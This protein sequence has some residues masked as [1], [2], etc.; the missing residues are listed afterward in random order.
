MRGSNPWLTCDKGSIGLWAPVEDSAVFGTTGVVFTSSGALTAGRSPAG[1]VASSRSLQVAVTFGAADENEWI[2]DKSATES[3]MLALS[4]EIKPDQQLNVPV[5]GRL[6]D[7]CKRGFAVLLLLEDPWRAGVVERREMDGLRAC[8]F[9]LRALDTS[10][11]SVD[12]HSQTPSL[13]MYLKK[14][15]RRRRIKDILSI[16]RYHRCVIELL[17]DRSC[18]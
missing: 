2:P 13:G 17:E 15:H 16:R 11:I 8:P 12:G 7:E 5:T 6:C 14:K 3:S 10:A 9:V 1:L 18:L 4:V